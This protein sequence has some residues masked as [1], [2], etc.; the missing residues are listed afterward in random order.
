MSLADFNFW[1]DLPILLGAVFVLTAA[2]GMV[3]FPDL[4]SRLHASS[5]M[6]T[7]GSLGIFFGAAFALQDTVAFSRLAAVL[8]FQFIT[9]PLSAYLIARSAYLRGIDPKL[10]NGVDEWGMKGQVGNNL[11]AKDNDDK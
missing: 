5:K 9:T 10:H 4:Y 8:L 3:R 7:L 6:V 11:G 2:V 1:R